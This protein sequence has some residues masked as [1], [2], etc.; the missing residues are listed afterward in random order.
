V[1]WASSDPFVGD[2]RPDL[3][4]S[5]VREATIRVPLPP[6]NWAMVAESAKIVHEAPGLA[7]R[8]PSIPCANAAFARLILFER[9]VPG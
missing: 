3:P 9:P 4:E 5:E 1:T 8:G 6:I 7:T 2:N